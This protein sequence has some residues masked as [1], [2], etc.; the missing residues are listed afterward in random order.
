MVSCPVCQRPLPQGS[1]VCPYCPKGAK[2]REPNP[3]VLANY[4]AISVGFVVLGVIFLGLAGYA[5]SVTKSGFFGYLLSGVIGITHGVLLLVRQEWVQSVTKTFC[6]AR[7][8]ICTYGLL[9]VIPWFLLNPAVGAVLLGFSLLEIGLLV[10]MIRTI[11]DVV[12][13]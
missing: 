4:H 2:M 5:I 12:F 10:A 9:I 11:D 13:P 8:A 6:W 1:V 3:R 7:F